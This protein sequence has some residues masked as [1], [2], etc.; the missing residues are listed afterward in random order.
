MTHIPIPMSENVPD[1]GVTHGYF[2][3][4]QKAATN[5]FL[6]SSLFHLTMYIHHI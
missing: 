6:K 4:T 2:K 5:K 1:A 3:Y